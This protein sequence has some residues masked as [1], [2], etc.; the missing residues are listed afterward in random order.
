MSKIRKLIDQDEIAQAVLELGARISA[1]YQGKDVTLLGVL[2][3]SIVLVTDL[4]RQIQIPHELGLVQASSYRGT[5][6][7]A[8]ELHINL[9]FLPDIRGRDILLIDDIFDTGKTLTGIAEKLKELSPNSIRTAVL[10]WKT[11]RREVDAV[12]D[13]F[14]FQ[15]PDEFV[16][17]YG[18]DFNNRYRHLPYIGVVEE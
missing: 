3:G 12:P 18:L 14:C 9:D 15:I 7:T 16:V 8:G 10:L 2:T 13:Y 1:D 11:V 5:A 17:G 4:M 6:T